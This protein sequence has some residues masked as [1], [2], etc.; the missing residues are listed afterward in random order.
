MET[1][2]QAEVATG[3]SLDERRARLQA[4]LEA[5]E[6]Q[7]EREVEEKRA[8]LIEHIKTTMQAAGITARDLGFNVPRKEAKAKPERK[9]VAVKY[10]GPAGETWTGRGRAPKW[11]VPL[12]AAGRKVEDFAVTA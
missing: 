5:I 9:P 4:E 11:L 1:N 2:E 10:K 3:E 7:A 8:A 6:E 12:L